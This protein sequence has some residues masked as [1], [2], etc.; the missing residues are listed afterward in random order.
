MKLLMAA[1]LSCFLTSAY[2]V[3]FAKNEG[4]QDQKPQ[5]MEQNTRTPSSELK[6]QAG[7]DHYGTTT[8]YGQIN[9]ASKKLKASEYGGSKNIINE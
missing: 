4:Y 2:A 3:N 8:D 7:Y 1:G 9:D 6:N 5:K